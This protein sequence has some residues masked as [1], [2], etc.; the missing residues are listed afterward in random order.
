[1][2]VMRIKYTSLPE[3]KSETLEQ[4]DSSTQNRIKLSR[5]VNKSVCAF[6]ISVWSLESF[7][8]AE[9]QRKESHNSSRSI[10]SDPQ[11][12]HFH[13]ME[14]DCLLLLTTHIWIQLPA[15]DEQFSLWSL[16]F[17]RSCIQSLP[18]LSWLLWANQ[19]T[20]YCRKLNFV[21]RFWLSWLGPLLLLLKEHHWAGLDTL[22]MSLEGWV[23]KVKRK[24]SLLCGLY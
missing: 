9:N 7:I 8:S 14:E 10:G 23:I 17:S 24:N 22:F 5:K 6:K 15:H 2:I 21:L 18:R 11:Y 20:E 4:S 12:I 13:W 16:G 19:E 3:G 1:M